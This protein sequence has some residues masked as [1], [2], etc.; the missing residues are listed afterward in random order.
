MA[1]KL[2]AARHALAGGVPL[3]RIGSLA[4]L[5]DPEAGTAVRPGAEVLV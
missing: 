3:V 5:T 4:I 2:E 1:V